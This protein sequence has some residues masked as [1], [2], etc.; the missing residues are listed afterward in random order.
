MKKGIAF[1]LGAA[2]VLSLAGCGGGKDARTIYDEASKKTSELKDMEITTTVDM[3]MVQGDQSID[4]TTAMDILMSGANTEE[5]KYLATGKTSMAGQDVDMS[6]YYADGYYYIES[7]GQKIK[8]AMD[9]NQ[10]ME[11]VKQSTEGANMESSYM[12]EIT[13]KKDG[14]NQVLTFT[15]DAEKMDAYVQDMM[16]SIGTAAAGM[17]GVSYKIKEASG[18]AVVNKDGYFTDM[19]MKMSMDMEVQGQTIGMDMDTAATYKNPGQAVTFE[20][21]DLEGYQEVDPAAMGIQ[22]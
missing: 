2:M 3:T 15:A 6:M 7:S 1:L 5:M 22:Q 11:Q 19:K 9:L 10:L 8:Y 4:M 16:S 14:D 21:P 12:K 20:E 13:A 17:E 18:E